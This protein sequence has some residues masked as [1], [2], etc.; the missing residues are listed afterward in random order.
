MPS[1]RILTASARG[2][3]FTADLYRGAPPW[4]RWLVTVLAPIE[5]PL[6]ETRV[7]VWHY[8]ADRAVAEE[9]ARACALALGP[10]CAR[11]TSHGY[12]TVSAMDNRRS[13]WEALARTASRRDACRLESP[14]AYTA[15]DPGGVVVRF[16]DPAHYPGYGNE[17][18]RSLWESM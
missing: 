18:A 5:G 10:A 8:F 1:P 9:W 7:T 14:V 4:A 17:P 13:R 16:T 2:D 15:I 6:V 12:V 11:A 3:G